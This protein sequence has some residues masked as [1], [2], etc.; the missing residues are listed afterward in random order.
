VQQAE[1]GAGKRPEGDRLRRDRDRFG[2]GNQKSKL[3]RM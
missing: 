2:A 3:A 1:I